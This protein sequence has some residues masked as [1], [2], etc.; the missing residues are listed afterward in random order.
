MSASLFRSLERIRLRSAPIAAGL[1]IAAAL[2]L[3]GRVAAQ[4]PAPGDAKAAIADSAQPYDAPPS[5]ESLDEKI[6]ILERKLELKDEEEDKKKS[7]NATVTAGKDGFSLVSADKES[8]LKFKFFQHIDGRYFLEDTASKL[9]NTLL[10]RRVRPVWEGNVG[11]YYNFR[12]MPEFSGTFAILDAYS[13]IAFIPEARLRVGKSKTPIGLERIKSSQD[14]DIIEFSHTTSLTPNYDLGI[15]LLGDLLDESV[16]YYAGVFNGAVDGTTRDVDFNDDKDLIGRVFALPF[17]AG[18]IEPLRNLGIGFAASFGY[19]KGDLS[20]PE[21]PAYRTEGQQTFFS[22]RAVADRASSVAFNN[23]TKVVSNTAAVQGDTGTVR[24][25]GTGYRLNPQGYWYYGPF[26]LFGEWI[27]SS[28]EY[29][30]GGANAGLKKQLTST[31][32][33]ATANYVLTGESPSFKGLKPRHPLS[34]GETKG[35]GALELVG[36]ASRLKVDEDAFP[37]FANPAASAR[38]ATTYSAGFNWYLSRYLKWSADYSWTAFEGGA[39][40]NRDRPE[41]K[42]FF[43][44]IQTAF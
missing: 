2:M 10:V 29:S 3:P 40:A 30:K 20:T 16:S 4:P 41:E 27:A 39:A 26:G 21:T 19:R 7:E 22:F 44:R 32:W 25:N 9:P 13:E 38:Q 5:V 37:V 36:R 23:T 8:A 1:A 24:A 6:R 42:V 31:A 17:K 43:S 14:M 12:V 15:S 11:K 34:F 33:Q 35:F 18:S 28:Q